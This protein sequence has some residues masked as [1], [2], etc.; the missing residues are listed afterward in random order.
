MNQS[1]D[2]SKMLKKVYEDIKFG[3]CKCA[4]CGE[5]IR[6]YDIEGGDFEYIET[7][8]GK[9]IYIHSRCKEKEYEIRTSE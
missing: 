5:E 1:K 2:N 9:S 3:R 8:R 7:R 4:I 6:Q